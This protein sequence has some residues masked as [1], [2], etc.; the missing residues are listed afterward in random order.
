M[1]ESSS[2]RREPLR[3]DP[4]PSQG[5]RDGPRR[6]VHLRGSSR[7]RCL[8]RSLVTRRR[9]RRRRS[10]VKRRFR[11]SVTHDPLLA[12]LFRFNFAFI[13]PS[14]TPASQRCIYGRIRYY[15]SSRSSPAQRVKLTLPL[16]VKATVEFDGVL[17]PSVCSPSV[18][19]WVCG[20]PSPPGELP[21]TTDLSFQH[22]SE[23]LGV[24][25]PALDSSPLTLEY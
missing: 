18:A 15:G 23:D 4:R 10:D 3:D 17:S 7:V 22:F 8:S 1:R 9:S 16:A 6:R 21:S 14:T 25:Q 11:L 5:A 2:R 24:S 12:S 19:F 20:N 13:I